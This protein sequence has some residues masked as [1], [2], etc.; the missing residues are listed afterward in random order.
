LTK[1]EGKIDA[2][3]QC[4]TSKIDTHSFDDL[5]YFI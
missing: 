2:W 3:K 4:K 5:L 1:N